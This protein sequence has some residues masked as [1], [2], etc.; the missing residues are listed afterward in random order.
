MFTYELQRKLD[1]AGHKTI[2]VGAHPGIATT[3]LSRHMPKVLYSILRYTI[4]PFLTHAPS[5]GAKPTIMAT[6]GNA[7]GS[8]YFG[9]TGFNEF[10]GKPGLATS[11]P[12]SKDEA[13]AKKLWETS[14]KLVG[15][16]FLKS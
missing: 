12:L 13:I 11:T 6:I 4:A 14:E 5:E 2:S 16:E 8:D 9:P 3:E 15:L 10:K 1:K 7:K